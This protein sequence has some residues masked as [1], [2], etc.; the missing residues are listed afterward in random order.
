[1]RL[2]AEKLSMS[3]DEKFVIEN[4]PSAGGIVAS[5]AALA[6]PHDGYTLLLAAT[7]NFSMAPSLFKTLSF[8]PADDFEM[9][10]LMGTFGYALAVSDSSSYRTVQDFID[11]AKAQPGK[12]SIGTVSVGSGQYLSA[13]LFKSATGIDAVTI[14]YKNSGSVVSALRAGDVQ[15]AFETLTPLMSNIQA[16]TLRALAVTEGQRFQ[17]LPEVPT[18][19]ESGVPDYKVEVWN[20]IAAAAGTPK[21]IIDQLNKEVAQ[22]LALPDVQERFL[23]LGITARSSTPAEMNAFLRRDIDMWREIIQQSNVPIQ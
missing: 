13:E 23:S 2:L 11:A 4:R 6:A 20:A 5:Q 19:M 17:G 18:M 14:P 1:M 15:A 22:A 16:G 21:G 10:S 12:L 9:I 7:G 8:D 3:M